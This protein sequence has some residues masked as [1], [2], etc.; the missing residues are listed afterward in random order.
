MKVG[1]AIELLQK[2]DPDSELMIS[3]PLACS[4]DRVVVTNETLDIPVRS[5]RVG[6]F[7]GTPGHIGN[8]AMLV[9]TSVWRLDHGIEGQP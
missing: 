3:A 9:G 1:R 4:K 5:I 7:S 2:L 6:C 8:Y